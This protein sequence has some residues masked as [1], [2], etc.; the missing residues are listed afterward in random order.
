[1]ITRA[2]TQVIRSDVRRRKEQ[3]GSVVAGWSKQTV[4]NLCN[5]DHPNVTEL[6]STLGESVH[7]RSGMFGST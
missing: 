5:D 4:T 1:M 6:S 7:Q 2:L 3:W